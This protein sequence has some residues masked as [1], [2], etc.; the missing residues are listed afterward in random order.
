[1]LPDSI[2]PNLPS[3][4]R[5]AIEFGRANFPGLTEGTYEGLT[6]HLLT[7]NFDTLPIGSTPLDLTSSLPDA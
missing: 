6:T 7:L 4:A 5:A 1:M 3:P 2:M